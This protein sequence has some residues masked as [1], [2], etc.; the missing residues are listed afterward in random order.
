MPHK[1]PGKHL[2]KGISFTKIIR[3][4]VEFQQVRVVQDPDG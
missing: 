4:F 2:R 3:I 1:T